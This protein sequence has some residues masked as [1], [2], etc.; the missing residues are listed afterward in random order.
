MKRSR[1]AAAV[2][3]F[4]L[5][6]LALRVPALRHGLPGLYVPDSHNV[7]AALGMAQSR[8]LVPR[9]NEFT[10]YPYLY[11]YACLP[12]FA[13]DYAVGRAT[14]RYASIEDYR[15]DAMRRLD[16]FHLMA[17]WLA[18]LAGAVAAA[19]AV[20][21]ARTLAGAR[22]GVFAGVLAATG[23]LTLLLSLHERP[24]AF[25]LAFV[26]ISIAAAIR[27]LKPD[28][29][30]R[31]L[32]VSALAA[33]AA[34]GSHQVG[35]AALAIPIAAAWLRP[36]AAA[37][38]RAKAGGLVLAAAA[39]AAAFLAG[40]PYLVRYGLSGAVQTAITE[41]TG[42]ALGGQGLAMKFDARFT[43]E[44]VTGLFAL[45]TVL[46]LLA[47]GGLAIAYAAR[48]RAARDL[49]PWRAAVVASA[50]VF[51]VIALCLAYTGTHSR[52]FAVV[53]PA[54][55]VFAGV[56]LDR[57]AS[58]G[59]IG[60]AAAV[61]LALI[62]LPIALRIDHLLLRED[63]R[64]ATARWIAARLPPGTRVAAE[65]YGPPLRASVAAL[66][67]VADVDPTL[68]TRREA[69]ALERGE[70]G[71]VD[72]LPLE[73]VVTDAAPGGYGE[74]SAA[75]K[76]LFPGART[77][78]EAIDAAGADYVVRVDRFPARPRSDPLAALVDARGELLFE[79]AP[80]GAGA[81]PPQEAL[82]P[83][84]PR[85]GAWALWSVERP[86]PRVRVY[87]LASR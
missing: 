11:S 41:E 76:K 20:D 9:S 87:R 83:V 37:S 14:G 57:L 59:T 73:R 18:A 4:F 23:P 67:R 55:W 81:A 13:A 10:S 68:L 8:D 16:R 70:P 25:V 1:P 6:A 52:Y 17:R 45:E 24:W 74:I 46:P 44:A 21:A 54:A 40:N 53:L 61:A 35:A 84:E 28:A 39:F 26:S 69:A 33:G 31:P 27:A 34:G 42:V 3:L 38:A 29:G 75:G 78:A 65:P 72:L 62:P 7:R 47:L 22:A 50:F 77:V 79:A 15:V 2:A 64:A 32:V 49:E 80:Q 19:A 36:A 5:L 51:P 12:L 71:G 82:L 85:L 86:G 43:R 48:E 66:R 58:T 30:W 63:T 56:L 60:F